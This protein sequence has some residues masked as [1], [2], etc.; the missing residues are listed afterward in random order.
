M[1]E[2]KKGGHVRFRPAWALGKL[3][4]QCKI[5]CG[6]GGKKRKIMSHQEEYEENALIVF[7]SF[8]GVEKSG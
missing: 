3:W 4:L 6:K 8:V 7:S 1:G 5:L 2:A